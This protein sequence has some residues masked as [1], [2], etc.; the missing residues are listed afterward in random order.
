MS[1]KYSVEHVRS[2]MDRQARKYDRLAITVY[3]GEKEIVRAYAAK[4][5]E[6]INGLVNRL[7]AR[8]IPDFE[9][10]DTTRMYGYIEPK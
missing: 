9:P 8:E 7:L 1:E 6:T 10:M 3:K 4:N 2:N 5:G